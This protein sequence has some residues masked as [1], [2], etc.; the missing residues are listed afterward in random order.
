MKAKN[1]LT[2]GEIAQ[3]CS[4]NLKTVLKWIERGDLKAYKLPGG[5]GDNRVETGAFIDFLEKNG[6]PIPE[7]I[8]PKTKRILIVDDEKEMAESIERSLH[9][10][11]IET[12]IAL[13]GFQAGLLVKSFKPSLITLDLHMP[14]MSGLEVIRF[15]HSHQELAHIK[16]L[17]ISAMSS[18]EINDAIQNG[19]DDALAK[20]YSR[21]QLVE[22]IEKLL[23]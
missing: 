13:D 14:G 21:D 6:M 1:I 11:G 2:T 15:I 3:F 10:K 18:N 9:G 23:K 5:R 12:A 16:I 19:A 17:V 22:K 4:V 7:E 8:L 20:G